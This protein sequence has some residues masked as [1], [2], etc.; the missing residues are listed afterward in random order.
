MTL[1]YDFLRLVPISIFHG[2]LE[3]RTMV[4][5]Q[6]LEDA[7]LVLQASIRPLRR[8]VHGSQSSPLGLRWGGGGRKACSSRCGR[9]SSLRDGAQRLRGRSMAGKHL[10]RSI[11]LCSCN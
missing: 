11:E 4:A 1:E 9:K 5:V 8:I 10:G 6:V 3:I 7:V 2:A